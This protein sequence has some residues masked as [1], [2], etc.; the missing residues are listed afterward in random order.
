MKKQ[1]ASLFVMF[2]LMMLT[3]PA[4]AAEP[5]YGNPYTRTI[6][7]YSWWGY[8]PATSKEGATPVVSPEKLPEKSS[9]TSLLAQASATVSSPQAIL[10]KLE[11]ANK[12]PENISPDL[13]IERSDVLNASTNGQ[14]LLITDSLL[15]KLTTDDERAFVISHE[16]SH[17]LLSHIGKTQIRR[18][19]LSL[20]DHFLGNKFGE[21]SLLTLASE[22]GINLIDL[23]SSR[24][25][26]YQADDLGIKLMVNAGYDPQAALRVFDVLEAASAGNN[27]PGFLRSHP[28]TK[29]R[30]RA[31][32]QKYKLSIN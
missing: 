13:Q 8:W 23:K 19:G 29:D 14:N 4:L 11:S 16:L 3:S 1:A 25:Y 12:V 18:T 24:G 31:L 5:V 7:G 17:I 20:L 22:L 32:V 26:E 27:T 9:D 15:N 28:L 10:D 30:I 21:N 2:Q 6:E